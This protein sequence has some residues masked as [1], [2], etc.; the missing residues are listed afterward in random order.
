MQGLGA[1][2][3]KLNSGAAS[4]EACQQYGQLAVRTEEPGARLFWDGV[5]LKAAVRLVWDI[6]LGV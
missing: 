5:G 6:K 1:A 2:N 4:V 3:E